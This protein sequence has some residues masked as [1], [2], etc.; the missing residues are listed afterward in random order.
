MEKS[1]EAQQNMFL[2][3]EKQYLESVDEKIKSSIPQLG[4]IGTKYTVVDEYNNNYRHRFDLTVKVY[5]LSIKNLKIKSN[6][7]NITKSGGLYD[8]ESNLEIQ[9]MD[10]S[11]SIILIFYIKT[12]NIPFNNNY[13]YLDY[14]DEQNN[15]Y[16]KRYQ[17]TKNQDDFVLLEECGL[18]D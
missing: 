12:N 5:N 15:K 4:F 13:L 2:L 7:W 6:F 1:V 18:V 11:K 3:T 8:N 10:T 16:T 9:S 17:I 14:Y